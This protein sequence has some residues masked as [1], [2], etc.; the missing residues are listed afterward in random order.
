VGT[1]E[2]SFIPVLDR[3]LVDR[4]ERC[5]SGFDDELFACQFGINASISTLATSHYLHADDPL[6][7]A[8]KLHTLKATHDFLAAYQLLRSSMHSQ[9][10]NAARLGCETA[11][12][13]AW[14][15]EEPRRAERWSAGVRVEPG[16]VRS[17]LPR[18][19]RQRKVLYRELSQLAH[20]NKQ[21]MI[22]LAPPAA[23]V[24]EVNLDVLLPTYDAERI[25]SMVF[26]LFYALLLALRDFD[27]YHL[28]ALNPEQR[29]AFG[30]QQES[31]LEY[32]ER[33]V[34]AELP[35]ELHL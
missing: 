23:G 30:K 20:P 18:L 11:W 6:G 1:I 35:L 21:A 5:M 13:N 3:L 34:K 24:K 26:L 4:V 14:F 19:Q 2:K 7:E 15:H 27:A 29:A 16:Q 28:K 22:C 31:M 33:L 17:Q 25:R 9:A 8:C 12:Q 10:A 32:Y